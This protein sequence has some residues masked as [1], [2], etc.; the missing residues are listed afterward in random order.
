[1]RAGRGRNLRAVPDAADRSRAP[2][3]N[4]RAWHFRGAGVTESEDAD[5]QIAWQLAG[6]PRDKADADVSSGVPAAQSRREAAGMAG[7]P[8]SDESARRSAACARQLAMILRRAAFTLPARLPIQRAA[9]LFC[10]LL[11]SFLTIVRV[12]DHGRTSARSQLGTIP[13]ASAG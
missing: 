7:Y 8:G 11:L 12:D 3:R 9:I 13:R 6:V 4:R 1:S 2:S 10:S 5:Q